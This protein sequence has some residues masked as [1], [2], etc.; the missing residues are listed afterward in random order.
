MGIELAIGIYQASFC[1]GHSLACGNDLAFCTDLTGLIGEWT[2][3]VD[4]K[5]QRGVGH[6]SRKGGVNGTAHAGVEQGS[7]VSAMHRAERIVEISRRMGAAGNLPA[8]IRLTNS[9]P[10]N[11]RTSSGDAT[12]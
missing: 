7:G 12:P 5:F 10:L 11:K 6:A 2:N 8:S 1:C 4:L 9:W 3:E